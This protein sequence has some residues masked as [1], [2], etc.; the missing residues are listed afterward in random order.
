MPPQYSLD[1]ISIQEYIFGHIEFLWT[2]WLYGTK[3]LCIHMYIT[4]DPALLLPDIITQSLTAKWIWSS[5]D[6][7]IRWVLNKYYRQWNKLIIIV[8]IIV[9]SM[10][11]LEW[12][13]WYQWGDKR[14]EIKKMAAVPFHVCNGFIG[15]LAATDNYYCCGCSLDFCTAHKWILSMTLILCLGRFSTVI[16]SF[17]VC[18]DGIFKR[19]KAV[20]NV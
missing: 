6:L 18:L 2:C 7:T 14:T 15:W 4:S 20:Y 1:W 12:D 16:D 3:F 11:I 8:T 13:W 19:P 10:F 17:T 5:W 9:P